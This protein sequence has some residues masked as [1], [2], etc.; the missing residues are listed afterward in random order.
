MY[1]CNSSD[2]D[3]PLTLRAGRF[4]SV[5]GAC[6]ERRFRVR[7]DASLHQDDKS[8]LEN[9][10]RQQQTEGMLYI[11]ALLD[12]FVMQSCEDRKNDAAA[13]S[14]NAGL[15]ASVYTDIFQDAYYQD[16]CERYK[17]FS[18]HDLRQKKLSYDLKEAGKNAFYRGDFSGALLNFQTVL[19]K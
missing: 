4:L 19:W 15:I 18:A 6:P 7:M 17:K 3:I 9:L 8:L 14:A 10:L 2:P 5:P 13:S 1:T 11:E 12:S 16:R